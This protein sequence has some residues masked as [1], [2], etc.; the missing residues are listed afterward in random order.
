LLPRGL[1]SWF[2]PEGRIHRTTEESGFGLRL[3]L[4]PQLPV[5]TLRRTII[6]A[7]VR[8]RRGGRYLENHSVSGAPPSAAKFPSDSAS[9]VAPSGIFRFL[10]VDNVNHGDKSG[11]TIFAM[12]RAAI[13]PLSIMRDQRP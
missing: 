11:G 8:H 7:N 1:P 4:L 9:R 2:L 12:R 10:A 6:L 5:P 13:V 3:A